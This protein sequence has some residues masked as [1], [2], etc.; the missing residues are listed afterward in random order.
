M[1][2]FKVISN[3]TGIEYYSEDYDIFFFQETVEI[4]EKQD[5]VHVIERYVNDKFSN[6]WRIKIIE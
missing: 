6:E 5:H 4:F 2:K 1:S 3:D